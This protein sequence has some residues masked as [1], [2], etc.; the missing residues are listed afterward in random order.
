MALAREASFLT[1]VDFGTAIRWSLC[2]EDYNAGTIYIAA[3]FSITPPPHH[4]T[5]YKVR[6]SKEQ[7]PETTAPARIRSPTNTPPMFYSA[8]K[9][10]WRARDTGCLAGVSFP[11]EAAHRPSLRSSNHV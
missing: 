2:G 7:A 6:S 11:S 9:C 5:S 10:N 3:T 1:I 8:S 4:A